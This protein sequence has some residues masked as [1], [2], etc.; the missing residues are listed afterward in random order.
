MERRVVTEEIE[1]T[2]N[3][4]CRDCFVRDAFRKDYG[5]KYAQRFCNRDCSIGQRLQT[6]GVALLTKQTEN[7]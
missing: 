2:L 1:W 7:N 3:T 4:Y 6:L 5:K